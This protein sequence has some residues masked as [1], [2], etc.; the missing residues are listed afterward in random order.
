M[1]RRRCDRWIGAVAIDGSAM[2][3]Y[4]DNVVMRVD[5]TK[6][7]YLSASGVQCSVSILYV[8]IYGLM[9]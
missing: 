3:Q 9:V 2:L 6:I 4:K 5:D 1:D 7:K 8:C